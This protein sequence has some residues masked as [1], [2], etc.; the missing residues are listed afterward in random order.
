MNHKNFHVKEVKWEDVHQ[1]NF[2]NIKFR[3]N[4]NSIKKFIKLIIFIII[5]IFSGVISSKLTIERKYK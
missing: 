4:R 3:K 2:G 1:D 5:A